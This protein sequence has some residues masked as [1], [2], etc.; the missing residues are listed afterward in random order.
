[1]CSSDLVKADAL[2]ELPDLRLHQ[3]Q[4]PGRLTHLPAGLRAEQCW[5]EA[6]P[7]ALDAAGRRLPDSAACLLPGLIHSLEYLLPDDIEI[8]ACE[9]GYV[10][11][12]GAKSLRMEVPEMLPCGDRPP[13][14]KADGGFLVPLE[15]G[16]HR[17][18]VR[19]HWPHGPRT[20]SIAVAEATVDIPADGP[21][22]LEL[23]VTLGTSVLRGTWPRGGLVTAYRGPGLMAQAVAITD[24]DGV[25][26]IDGLPA[27]EYRLG[28]SD[29]DGTQFTSVAARDG[30][31]TTVDP[32][33]KATGVL[34]G[35]LS[36]EL[37]AEA[38]VSAE[39]DGAVRAVEVGRDGRFAISGLPNGSYR[40]SV[41][42]EAGIRQRPEPASVPGPEVVLAA[43]PYVQA[44]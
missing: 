31:T 3:R 35:R 30:Q 15:P 10:V 41:W 24:A 44:P 4:V 6:A 13:F 11:Y 18:M 37:P 39:G 14:A 42:S 2:T 29:G 22:S 36:G 40:L 32:P 34:R 21:V 7:V 20:A 5:V 12:P 17:L 23:P 28:F 26:R 25:W 27:G 8:G 43:T 33:A 19:T 9:L 1:M 16:R 38:M